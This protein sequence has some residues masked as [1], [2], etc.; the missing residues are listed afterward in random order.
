MITIPRAALTDIL[1][2][3]DSLYQ[4]SCQ[5]RS[6][7]WDALFQFCPIIWEGGYTSVV[8]ESARIDSN[9]TW[10]DGV[11]LNFA[12]N[13]LFTAEK[14]PDGH[15]NNN[16]NDKFSGVSTAGKEDDKIALTEIRE[17][18]AEPIVNLTWG[19]FRR[20]TGRMIQAM[21]A[22]GVTRGDRVAIVAGNSIDTLVVFLA[23]AALGG[24]F[25]STSTDTGVKGILDR[26][27]QVRPRYVF[28]DD[29]TVYNG[30]TLDLRAKIVDVVN[31]LRDIEEFQ[32]VVA[33]P[34]FAHKPADV[35]KVP[36]T[37]TLRSFL[38]KARS[39][40][41]IFVRVGFRDPFLIVY[42]SGTTGQPK[43]IVH[44]VGGVILNTH[45]E[46]RLNRDMTSAS[47]V[48]QYTTTGWIMYLFS[49]SVLLMGVR[50]VL[51][52]GSPFLPDVKVLIRIL[53]EQRLAPAR[54][55]EHYFGLSHSNHM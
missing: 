30:K 26:L 34:R 54:P 10:F 6:A 23:T 31:G 51:Y 53:G 42:S 52:D 13:M 35:G 37:Q 45:K 40:K 3:Y 2:D 8:D 28:F 17:G 22:A 12:E 4:W 46:G 1:Q 5:N 27:V 55:Q 14:K 32:G 33:I 29:A 7:F 41:L 16:N 49:V 38:S 19:E 20:R 21:K 36:R 15:S 50:S 39:D 47:T 24:L 48:L 43:C 18:A 9:P 11:R 25:S 44:C